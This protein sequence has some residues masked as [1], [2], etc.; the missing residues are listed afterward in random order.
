MQPDYDQAVADYP[1][2]YGS[3]RPEHVAYRDGDNVRCY[4]ELDERSSQVANGL[5]AAGCAPRDRVGF[6]GVNSGAFV[7]AFFGA[8]KART[9]YV[10][11][12]WR[13]TAV[14]LRHILN[15]AAPK[16]IFCDPEFVPLLTEL[17]REVPS[18]RVIVSTDQ[19]A[20][21]AWRNQFSRQDPRLDHLPDDGIVQFY[22]SGT[23]GKPKG[24]VITNRAM[25]EHRRGEDG[26]GSWYLN[27]DRHEVTINAMPNFHI[28]GLGWLLIS[29]FRGATVILMASPDP[30]LFLDLIEQHQV[31]HLF[32]VPTVLGMMVK[33]QKKQPRDLH[34]LQVLHY[35]SSAIAPTLLREA[36]QVMNCGF[37]QYYGMTETIGSVTEISIRDPE[38]HILPVNT[39]GEI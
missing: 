14:E 4:R 19:V 9:V 20:F 23:T 37:A 34:S 39:P 12:N 13:L 5:I 29:M 2:G 10:G 1:R 22:T 35:G 8:C 16:L 21:N 33:E 28:G 24:A 36:L 3:C 11:L 25:G 31:S 15:D 7:E 18:L 6:M 26:F 38:G 27:S 32:A 30:V 17:Q